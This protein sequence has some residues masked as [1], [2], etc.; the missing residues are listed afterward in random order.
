MTSPILTA[1][2]LTISGKTFKCTD[3]LK[4]E[5]FKF[6][7]SGKVWFREVN[8]DEAGA[9]YYDDNFQGSPEGYA[10]HWNCYAKTDLNITLS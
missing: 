10:H 1:R 8:I 3:Q 9:I 5:G 4:R 7:G 6:D 2:L